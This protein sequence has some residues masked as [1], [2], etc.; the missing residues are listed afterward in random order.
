VIGRLT[1]TIVERGLDGVA[2]LDVGGVGYDVHVPLATLGRLPAPP[3]LVTLHVHTHVR[4]DALQ[5]FGFATL[6]DRAAFRTLLS[7]SS[8]GPKVAHTILSHLDARSLAAAI[9]RDDKKTLTSVPGVGKKL[10]E[11]IVLELRDKLGFAH[12]G[13]AQTMSAA[14]PVLAPPAPEGP[15]AETGTLLVSLGFKPAEADRA[16]AVIGK[17]SEGKNVEALLKEALAVLG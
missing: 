13:S 8:I 11:R 14:G 17:T 4:E 10:A 5:L 6:D 12:A 2:V 15:L 1:G 16:L 7:V 3:D 9:A